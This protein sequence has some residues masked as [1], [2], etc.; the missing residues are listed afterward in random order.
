MSVDDTCLKNEACDSFKACALQPVSGF[1]RH[2]CIHRELASEN[3]VIEPLHNTLALH[4]MRGGVSR[5][6]ACDATRLLV[7]AAALEVEKVYVGGVTVVR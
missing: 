2:L 4:T 5:N 7:V 1:I 6:G 3:G